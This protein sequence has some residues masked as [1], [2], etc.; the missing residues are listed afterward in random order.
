MVSV[1][2]EGSVMSASLNMGEPRARSAVPGVIGY[3]P[4]ADHTNHALI[5][6]RSSLPASPSG[7][8]VQIWSWIF[9]TVSWVW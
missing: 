9:R 8:S 1:L 7:V 4:S 3:R 6:P 2:P 5:V